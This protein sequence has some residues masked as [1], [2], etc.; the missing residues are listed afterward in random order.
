MNNPWLQIPLSDYERHMALPS[1][2]QAALLSTELATALQRHRPGSVAIV[3]CSGGNGFGQL[4]S[5][6]LNRVVGIDINPTYIEA[7][8][9]RYEDRLAGLELHVADIESGLSGIL[10][11]DL[12]FAGLLF[13]HVDIRRT[14]Q[15]LLGLLADE[16]TLVIVLQ[17]PHAAVSMISPSPYTSLQPLSHSMQLRNPDEVLEI[18][19]SL[20]L[21]RMSSGT[22]L[23]ASGKEFERLTF[24][25]CS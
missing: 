5:M 8:R 22:L 20:G 12:I 19:Q 25:R 23:L 2:G 15:S 3:G 14:L 7:A 17:R 1:V 11:V 16:G 9:Q 21:S 6:H 24:R 4:E 13:E 18:G 10:P